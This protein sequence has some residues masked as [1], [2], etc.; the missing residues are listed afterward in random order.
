[1]GK[2]REHIN[3]GRCGIG[4]YKLGK[5]YMATR[6]NFAMPTIREFYKCI[7]IKQNTPAQT[8]THTHTKTTHEYNQNQPGSEWFGQRGIQNKKVSNCST[9]RLTEK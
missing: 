2:S 5:Y 1:M 7:T 4:L 6:L 8:D 9:N 3:Q